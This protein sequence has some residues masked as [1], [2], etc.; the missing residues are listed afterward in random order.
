MTGNCRRLELG[1]FSE[2]SLR[3]KGSGTLSWPRPS[4]WG[5]FLLDL[6][7]GRIKPGPALRKDWSYQANAF[8]FPGTELTFP[9]PIVP[10]TMK[11]SKM[12]SGKRGGMGW[13]G[14]LHTFKSCPEPTKSRKFGAGAPTCSQT[15]GK[16]ALSGRSVSCPLGFPGFLPRFTAQ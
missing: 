4:A 6:Q 7:F 13:G 1:P 14:I 2:C 9:I 10:R 16:Q 5:Y 8:L 15:W 3:L 12:N 11:S